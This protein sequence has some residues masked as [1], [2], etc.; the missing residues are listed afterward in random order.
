LG[1]N[2][3]DAVG[4][5]VY[6][7]ENLLGVRRGEQSAENDPMQSP[8]NALGQWQP[9]FRPLDPT[10]FQSRKLNPLA[11]IDMNQFITRQA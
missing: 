11:M 7:R 4:S 5:N 1:G 2:Q 6:S 10:A 9:Q 8:Q 3:G